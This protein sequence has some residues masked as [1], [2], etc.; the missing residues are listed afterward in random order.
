MLSPDCERTRTSTWLRTTS[1][2]IVDAGMRA[3]QRRPSA[4]RGAQS[5]STS[6]LDAAAAERFQHRVD[7]DDARAARG[8]GRPV[9]AVA[10]FSFGAQQVR[11][12]LRHRGA[13]RSGPGDDRN[14]A[15]VGN[16][17]PLVRIHGPR[18]GVLESVGPRSHF[19][20][21]RLR[22]PTSRTHRPRGPT[23]RARCACSISGAKRIEGAGVHV[24][25]LQA[26]NRR[27]CNRAS[28]AA[29][30]IRQHAS[31][32]VGRHAQ[33]GSTCRTRASAPPCRSPRALRRRRRREGA[34]RPGRP[35][36]STSQPRAPEHFVPR[37]RQAGHVR[38]RRAGHET[39]ARMRRQAGR[40]RAA[41]AR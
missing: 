7:R 23:R 6:S 27:S 34:A 35:S 2:R 31:L 37:R 14:P 10:P 40:N 22:A 41:T 1:L 13:V 8:F 19:L 12:V 5:F 29:R 38:H 11:G 9:H 4:A 15:V 25:G 16:V 33:P 3:Q 32:A 39:D 30:R 21:D 17:Q 26:D 36:A 24:A 18:V 28:A 20:V